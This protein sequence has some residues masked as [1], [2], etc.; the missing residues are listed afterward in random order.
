MLLVASNWVTDLQ[1]ITTIRTSN[2]V[3][4]IT[5]KLQISGTL[6]EEPREG[7]GGRIQVEMMGKG[8]WLY[9]HP[10]CL[11]SFR[12]SWFSCNH[13]LDLHRISQET[14]VPFEKEE[15]GG[16]RKREGRKIYPT[17]LELSRP[18]TL[19]GLMLHSEKLCSR[20][21]TYAHIISVI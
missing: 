14:N 17:F 20:N 3:V 10:H 12:L 5:F 9:A 21:N 16:I 18:F 4:N 19:N 2:D 15:E 11:Q 6:A 7:R 1:N 8:W 13:S